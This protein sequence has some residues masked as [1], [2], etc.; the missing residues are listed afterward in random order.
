MMKMLKKRKKKKSFLKRL[1]GLILFL[2][3]L[4]G[5]TFGVYHYQL[6]PTGDGS[7]IVEFDIEKGQTFD[8][9]L[10]HLKEEDLIRSEF[11]TRMYARFTNHSQYFAGQFH[12]NDGMSTPAILNHIKNVENA[13]KDQVK[14]VVPEGTWAK[15]IASTIEKACPDLTAK[16]IL[17]QWNDTS[18]L[19]KLAKDYEFLNVEDL[20]NSKYRVKLEGYLFPDTY[21]VEEDADIDTITRTMLD[22]FELV[23]QEYKDEIEKSQYSMQELLTLASVVQFESSSP[24]QMKKIAQ[25]FYNRLDQDMKLESSV[26]VCYA[27]YDKFNNPTDCEIQIDVDSPYNT[28][29]N[30]G[31]PIGPILN[32][33]QDAIDAVLHPEEHDYLFFVADINGDGTIYYSHTLE[34]HEERVKE[35]NLVLE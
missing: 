35:L 26:T 29:A 20:N 2:V 3:L 22:R 14:I 19:K 8:Q 18:Y 16:E 25:V 11:A 13:G 21:Y 24:E 1:I 9:V 4:C 23:Y 10:H 5:G 17:K 6:R 31:L 15:D 28:Y 27:L 32:P 30:K 12:L 33:G 7:R 34:E